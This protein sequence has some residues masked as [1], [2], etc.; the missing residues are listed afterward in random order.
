MEPS[1]DGL[2]AE[3]YDNE[4]F[5]GEPIKQVDDNINFIWYNNPPTNGINAENFSIIWR[6]WVRAPGDGKYI[7]HLRCDDGCKMSFN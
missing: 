5:F 3:Y 4:A 2:K 7:F 6:G 1:G